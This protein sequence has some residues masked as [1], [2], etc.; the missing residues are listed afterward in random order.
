VLLHEDF[1]D[2]TLNF[3][4]SHG[5]FYDTDDDHFTIVPLNGAP[6][7]VVAYTGFSN[8][9]FSAEDINDPQGGGPAL[10]T[11]TFTV[12]ISAVTGNLTFSGLFAA[13]NSTGPTPRYDFDDFLLVQA[14]IDGN[15][16][17]NLLA[18]ETASATA[19]N[20]QILQDTDF[21]GIGDGAV[22]TAAATGFNNIP[23]SGTGSSLEV[24]IQVRMDAGDEEIAF[25]EIFIEGDAIPEPSSA[26][27]ALAG[28]ALLFGRR[29]K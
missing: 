14:S 2:N 29:R 12:D 3:T 23:I 6:S 9:Y 16:P 27:L 17:Q 28:S 11:L 7:P 26:L 1:E 10:Q 22:L 18:F 19:F 5:L 21:D 25:D 4:S 20:Q 13:G 24:T 8:N 15:T